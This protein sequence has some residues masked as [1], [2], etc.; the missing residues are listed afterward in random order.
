M[1]LYQKYLLLILFVL[2]LNLIWELLHYPL[3]IDLSGIAKYPHILLASFTDMILITS[4]FLLASL[5]NK[6][7]LWINN[8]N[9]YDYS[10]IFGL[11]LAIA[12]L[13]ELNALRSG[14]WAYTSLM[15][16]IFGIG[17]SP[18]LQLVTT[19]ILALLLI[20]LLKSIFPSL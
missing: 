20:K 9:R 1:K 2:L 10:T 7:F 18:L 15:P 8:P 3:Y 4:V 19:S 14:R 5:K 12:V 13:I 16:T 17:L 6:N 11:G